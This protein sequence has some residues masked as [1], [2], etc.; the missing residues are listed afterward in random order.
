M[1]LMKLQAETSVVTC[2]NTESSSVDLG[3]SVVDNSTNSEPSYRYQVSDIL[4]WSSSEDFV[5]G[6]IFD[7]SAF[8]ASVTE[9]T[10]SAARKSTVE[11]TVELQYFDEELTQWVVDGE[12]TASVQ[13]QQDPYIAA[14]ELPAAPEFP[15]DEDSE[16]KEEYMSNKELCQK[17]KDEIMEL[18]DKVWQ[19][20]LQLGQDFIEQWTN[21]IYDILCG[22]ANAVNQELAIRKAKVYD[23]ANLCIKLSKTND[24]VAT[25][26]RRGSENA[27]TEM[28]D[29]WNTR[30]TEIRAEQDEIAQDLI[31]NHTMTEGGKS[32]MENWRNQTQAE[33]AEHM[34]DGALTSFCSNYFNSDEQSLIEQLRNTFNVANIGDL[35]KEKFNQLKNDGRVLVNGVT[36]MVKSA[37]TSVTE[38]MGA[39]ITTATGPGFCTTNIMQ[40]RGT[41]KRVQSQA[42]ALVPCITGMIDAAIFLGLPAA[43][44]NSLTGIATTLTLVA[45]I[46]IP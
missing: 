13:I 32:A 35:I 29:N 5:T 10:E 37:I 30:I 31:D 24:K 38:P 17:L 44:I 22:V 40:I 2:E 27:D 15:S 9:N 7:G 28:L 14:I 6:I 1:A 26:L 42:V 19:D 18:L 21:K 23:Y 4:N 12:A 41:V 3:I 20:L 36:E 33:I 11:F 45:S 34:T 43:L 25:E 39:V 8:L 46:P 16:F